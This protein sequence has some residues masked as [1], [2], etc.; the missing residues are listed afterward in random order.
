MRSFLINLIFSVLIMA[1][2][3]ALA[4][5]QQTDSVRIAADSSY[6]VN[7]IHSF[8]LGKYY[9]DVWT[10]PVT[11]P[12]L[13]INKIHGGLKPHE[14]G[15]GQQTRNLHMHD[16]DGNEYALR[17]I[18]KFPDEAL[19]EEL[20]NPIA[21]FLAKDQISSSLPYGAFIIAALAG[22]AG[23][24]HTNPELYFVNNDPALGEHAENFAG[25]LY[26]VE[27]RP[28]NFSSPSPS[29]GNTNKW[30]ESEDLMEERAENLRHIPDQRLFAKSRLFDMVVGD[31]DRHEGQWDWGVYK[32]DSITFYQPVPVDR[33]NAFYNFDGFLPWFFSRSWAIPKFQLYEHHIRD[34][35]GFNYNARFNDR[36]FLNELEREDWLQI[37]DSLQ[38]ALTDEA[39]ENAV[40]VLPG[41][42][43][44][45]IGEFLISRMKSRRNDLRK[46]AEVYYAALAQEVNA[47]GSENADY[48]EV[49]REDDQNTLISV[50]EIT[51]DG[52]LRGPFY[53]RRFKTNETKEVR[54][55]GEEG[56]DIFVVKG[57]VNEGILIRIMGGLD[58]DSIL[59]DSKV[60]GFANKVIYYDY[61]GSLTI[62]GGEATKGK[63]SNDSTLN[64][65]DPKSYKRPYK[66]PIGTFGYN[67][68]DGFFLEGGILIKKFGFEEGEYRAKHRLTGTFDF[69]QNA[70]RIDYKSRFDNIIRRKA[71]LE[72]ISYIL[73]PDYPVNFFGFGNYSLLEDTEDLV[74]ETKINQTALSA[75][76]LI[77]FLKKFN[78]IFSP[79]YSLTNN[80]SR[81][82]AGIP[83]SSGFHLVNNI[84]AGPLDTERLHYIGADVG[85]E[86]S[87]VKNKVFPEKG[88]IFR[89]QTGVHKELSND[90]SYNKFEGAASVYLPIKFLIVAMRGGM[91]EQN[92]EFFFF[93]APTLGNNNYL[94]GFRQNRFYGDR[95]FYQNTDLRFR[96]AGDS[97]IYLFND[98]GKVQNGDFESDWKHGY[99]GG[100]FFSPKKI[101]TLTA[102]YA[103]SEEEKM[104]DVR[105]GFLF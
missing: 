99:G 93:E 21:S 40:A 38:S 95:I 58:A 55:Y 96:L 8:F 86:F 70:F 35:E 48:F 7:F 77:P 64:N 46:L 47:F 101:F 60:R 85:L 15:G 43:Y 39:I 79:Q 92:G 83:H 67:I 61:P 34:I 54:L 3:A 63:I 78:F 24:Y 28:E 69:G 81:T 65:Y 11:V 2:A 62:S 75:N 19:P 26:M 87:T 31:W 105:F 41:P 4:Q 74:Y 27:E 36:Y 82:L 94:R 66:G 57:D 9:R 6:N 33:D 49:K 13:D 23:I 98:F 30:M 91:A 29:F 56:K 51:S 12:V 88:V 50:Y 71:D 16:P 32:N 17:S 76:L 45:T 80:L 52:D 22:T 44:D 20:R 25:S 97:G 59:I 90:I 72:I 37:S 102:S 14:L 68:D 10:T 1:P 103:Q 18:Q 73:A 42:I 84:F 53:S 89:A 5:P 100:L 104:L